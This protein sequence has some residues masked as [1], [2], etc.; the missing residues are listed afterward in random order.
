[1]VSTTAAAAAV[2]VA[3]VAAEDN[4]VIRACMDIKERSHVDRFNVLP[5]PGGALMLG[6][7]SIDLCRFWWLVWLWWLSPLVV[8]VDKVVVIYCGLRDS[9]LV[10]VGS[11]F[12]CFM[13]DV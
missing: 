9:C 6:T 13:V 3:A 7:T 2:A 10:N 12:G 4:E 8:C 5:R 11:F 1:M